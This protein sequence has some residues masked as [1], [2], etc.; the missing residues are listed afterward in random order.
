MD[1]LALT[2][3]LADSVVRAA[4]DSSNCPPSRPGAEVSPC[5]KESIHLGF[6][7]LTC[8][9]C[10]AP[11]GEDGWCDVVIPDEVWNKI[12]D[13]GVL[14]FRCM[15]KRLEAAGLECVPVIITSGPYVDANEEWRLIGWHHGYLVG[16][17]QFLAM[18]TPHQQGA[19]SPSLTSSTGKATAENTAENADKIGKQGG[20]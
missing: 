6:S 19:Q 4:S 2:E 1:R 7:K 20:R 16:Q 17:E 18:R 13:G 11:Y 14:C 5:N 3:Q 15:T 9:D 8:M 12:V 10:P